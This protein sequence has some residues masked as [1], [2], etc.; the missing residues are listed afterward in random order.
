MG[1]R[2][3]LK[4]FLTEQLGHEPSEHALNEAMRG[5]HDEKVWLD[6]L[7]HSGL[8]VE[9]FQKAFDAD[10]DDILRGIAGLPPKGAS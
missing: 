10:T 3:R 4:A 5:Y 6:A 7:E 9:Q 1:L 2:K 8:T